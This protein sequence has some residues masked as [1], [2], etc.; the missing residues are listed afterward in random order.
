MSY[1]I[2]FAQVIPYRALTP[3]L[4]LFPALAVGL[5]GPAGQDDSVAIVDTG[6]EYSFFN[7]SRAPALGLSLL[8]GRKLRLA[9]LGGSFEGYLHHIDLE[10]EG[11]IFHAEVVFSVNQI[12][13]EILGR[14]SLFQLMTW[15]LRES[16]QEIYFSPNP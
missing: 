2:Q 4:A 1:N 8:D 15:G 3:G 10:I 11:S 7:G 13:R 12:P 14:H 9:S 16:R 5:I 6:A